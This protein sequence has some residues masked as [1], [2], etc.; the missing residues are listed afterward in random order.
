M[1]ATTQGTNIT[2]IDT[3]S[4]QQDIQAH[5]SGNYKL[6]LL[7]HST[8]EAAALHP[9]LNTKW[10]FPMNP[11]CN[12]RSTSTPVLLDRQWQILLLSPFLSAVI[13]PEQ[14]NPHPC[15]YFKTC[16]E[17]SNSGFGGFTITPSL[18]WPSSASLSV[19][20]AFQ[21]I[22][23]LAQSHVSAMSFL[24]QYCQALWGTSGKTCLFSPSYHS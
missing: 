6:V 13:T 8:T 21:V 17:K 9:Q 22:F 24:L 15:F 10:Q 3:N 18:H 1:K 16:S 2:E 11:N 12:S 20:K 4:L 19:L 23:Q 14:A 7:Y 5:Y